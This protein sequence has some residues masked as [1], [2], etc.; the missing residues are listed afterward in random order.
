L[1]LF[2]RSRFRCPEPARE[3][4]VGLQVSLVRF[5]IEARLQW[6]RPEILSILNL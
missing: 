5:D 3:T 1:P 2:C 6:S 4:F